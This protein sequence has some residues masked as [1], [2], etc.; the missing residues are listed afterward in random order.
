MDQYSLL[1]FN[2]PT[3]GLEIVLEGLNLTQAR[4]VHLRDENLIMVGQYSDFANEVFSQLA[5]YVNDPKFNFSLPLK[6]TGSTHQLNVWNTMLSI[7]SGEALSYGEVARLIKSSP[8]AVGGACGKNPLP[9]FIPC[10]RIIAA[11]GQLGGFNSG[12]LDLGLKI[13]KWLLEHEG[14]ISNN[15]SNS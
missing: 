14:L 4:F 5:N 11:K 2:F 15:G 12:N 7:R 13:K 8:R 6:Y 10:H 1:H 9:I 3:F